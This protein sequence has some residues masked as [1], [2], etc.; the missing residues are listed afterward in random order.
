VAIEQQRGAEQSTLVAELGGDDVGATARRF[1]RSLADV[2][3]R[4]GFVASPADR[5]AAKKG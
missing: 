2:A 4:F 5:A 3:T 1:E